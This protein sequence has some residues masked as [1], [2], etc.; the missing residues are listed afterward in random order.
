MHRGTPSVPFSITTQVTVSCPCF[1][2]LSFHLLFCSCQVF[3]HTL[4]LPAGN[5]SRFL[6]IIFSMFLLFLKNDG[7]WSNIKFKTLIERQCTTLTAMATACIDLLHCVGM[8]SVVVVVVKDISS[9]PLTPLLLI[10]P[11]VNASWY[12]YFFRDC[13]LEWLFL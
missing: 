12:K 5:N 13:W 9:S 11:F 7:C 1:P 2:L 8:W 3:A 10:K 6:F 4:A